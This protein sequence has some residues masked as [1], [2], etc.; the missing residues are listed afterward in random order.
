MGIANCTCKRA[1]LEEELI[2]KIFKSMHLSEQN[3]KD[4]YR[5]FL[6]CIIS[7]SNSDLDINSTS[8]S[9][10]NKSKSAFGKIDK[11]LYENFVCKIVSPIQYREAQTDYFE[12]LIQINDVSINGTKRIGLILIFLSEGEFMEKIDLLEKHIEKYYGKLDR[13]FKDFVSDVIDLNTDMCLL[14][15]KN[16]I[17]EEL[18]KFLTQVWK[19]PRKQKL[20]KK[21]VHI[22]DEMKESVPNDNDW[23]VHINKYLISSYNNLTGESIRNY[24]HEQYMQDSNKLLMSKN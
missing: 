7:D 8:S 6:A 4:V 22:Y 15:F 3:V 20:I 23:N 1:E 17:G 24:L 11:S 21:L 13:H 16:Y 2:T 14:S 12:T 18:H 10:G 5:N 19:K 9:S